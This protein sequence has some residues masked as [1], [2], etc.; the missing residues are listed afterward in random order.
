M[1]DGRTISSW[2][3]VV[4]AERKL[5]PRVEYICEKPIGEFGITPFVRQ[6]ELPLETI[7]PYRTARWEIQWLMVH[8]TDPTNSHSQPETVAQ[9]LI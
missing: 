1:A 4:P 6:A 3:I 7:R 2:K 5:L 8:C 9:C